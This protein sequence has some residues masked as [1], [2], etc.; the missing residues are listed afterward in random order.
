MF[1]DNIGVKMK[2]KFINYVTELF[3]A[4]FEKYYPDKYILLIFPPNDEADFNTNGEIYKEMLQKLKVDNQ[5]YSTEIILAGWIVLIYDNK[6]DAYTDFI[7]T[8]DKKYESVLYTQLYKG[9]QML[10]ENT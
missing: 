3:E 2:I 1:W 6:D 4:Y 10:S 9:K 7:I 8:E 5:K